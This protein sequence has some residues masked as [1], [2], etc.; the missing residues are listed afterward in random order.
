MLKFVYDVDFKK[1][2]DRELD[3]KMEFELSEVAIVKKDPHFGAKNKL[4]QSNKAAN[5][6]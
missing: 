3:A 2:K 6:F 1:P 5:A 4:L